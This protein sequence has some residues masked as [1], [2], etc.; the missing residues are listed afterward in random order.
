LNPIRLCAAALALGAAPAL[1]QPVS[2]TVDKAQ[3]TVG[4]SGKHAGADF[5]GKFGSWDAVILFD[6]ADLAHSSA[7]VTFQTATAKTGDAAE[8]EA[9]GQEE[10]LN[11]AK[12][13]TATFTSTQISSAGGSNYVA[14]GTLALKGKT[15]PV[16]LSFSLTISGNSATMKGSATVD[17]LV[18]EIGTLS[19]ANGTFVSK[20]IGITV[21][22]VAKK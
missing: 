5:N 20:D 16:S 10:W 12:F 2:W 4:F 9:L 1:A 6:P 8:D 15:L 18:Y 7:K 22:L 21:D 14:K 3:S 11:P 13:P 19:D 17:R